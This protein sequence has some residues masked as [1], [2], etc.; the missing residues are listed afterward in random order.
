MEQTNVRSFEIAMKKEESLDAVPAFPE[1]QL[2][3]YQTT[4][5]AG[6]DFFCAEDVVIPTVFEEIGRAMIDMVKFG[7][8]T[9]PFDIKPT[10]VHTGVKSNMLDDEVLILAN[11]SSNPKKLGLILA[12]GIGVID[13]DYYGNPSNDGEIMFAFYNVKFRSVKLKA[14]DRVGQGYFQKYL[15]PTIGLRE[16]NVV[17]QGGLGSTN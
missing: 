4:Y 15:R 11:R 9:N 12:N 3:E 7:K 6:A 14:G 8:I 17:R 13:K 5:A 16:K 10:L 2:P 1:A